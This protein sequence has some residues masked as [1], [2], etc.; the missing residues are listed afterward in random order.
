MSGKKERR[1]LLCVSCTLWRET[2]L[3]VVALAL[4]SFWGGW[5]WEGVLNL[6][7]RQ[8]ERRCGER[9]RVHLWSLQSGRNRS[10]DRVSTCK[11]KAN[12]TYCATDRLLWVCA[13]ECHGGNVCVCVFC[14]ASTQTGRGLEAISHTHTHTHTILQSHWACLA[15][16]LI[17]VHWLFKSNILLIND[18]SILV[19]NVHCCY[20]DCRL[21]CIYS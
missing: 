7:G 17:T 10:G 3:L 16:F 2:V 9:R 1:A 19:G 11:E 14:L 20:S 8:R 15:Y 13:H 6:S 5:V 12:Q 18:Q 21:E 4:G